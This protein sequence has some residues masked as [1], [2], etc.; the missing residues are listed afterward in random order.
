MV[1]ECRSA[2]KIHHSKIFHHPD[3]KYSM[4]GSKQPPFD[5]IANLL[6]PYTE[7]AIKFGKGADQDTV[8]LK[9]VCLK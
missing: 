4:Q 9:Y 2:K 3:G 7:Q 6:S 5:S 1:S 8:L